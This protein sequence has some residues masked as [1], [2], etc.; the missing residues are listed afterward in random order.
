MSHE[1]MTLSQKETLNY[2]LPTTATPDRYE[3]K[4]TP[5]LQNFTFSGEETIDITVHESASEIILNAAELAIHSAHITNNKGANILATVSCDTANERAS[6]VLGKPIEPGLWALHIKFSGIL[7][8]RLHG[9]YRS[10]YQDPSGTQQVIATTQFE[11]TDARRAFPCW[12]EPDCKAVFKISLVIDPK[13]TAISNASVV[14]EETLPGTNKKQVNFA[15]TMKM[16]TYLVAFIVGQFEATDPIIV[17]GTPIRVWCVPGKKHLAK[18]ALDS[19]SASLSFFSNYYEIPY[20]GDKMDLIAL[21]DFASG[22]MENL[23]AITFRENALLVDESKASHAELERI[24]DVVAHEIAHMWFGDLVTMKWW[25]GIWLNEAFATFM[26]MLAVDAWKPEWRRWE[27][28]G[29]SRAAAFA[30]DGLQSTRSIEFPVH[31]PDEAAGMFD[32][33]TYEKGASVLRMLEQYLGSDQL[34]QGISLYLKKHQYANA[35]TTDLWDA[36]EASSKQPVRQLM[37]SWIFQGGYPLVSVELSPSGQ[38]ITLSQQRF[39]YL[40]EGKSSEQIFHIPIMLRAKTTK[41]IVTKK[42]LLT[43]RETTVDFDSK[44]DWIVVNDGGHG[45]YRVR[46]STELLGQ[47]TARLWENLTAIERFNL[48]SDTWAAAMAGLLPLSE[49][50]KLVQQFAN[51]TDKNVWAIVI[52]SLNYLNKIIEPAQRPFFEQFVAKLLQSQ[53]NRLGW[54]PGVGE[55]ELSKQLRGMLIGA[56]G[57]LGNDADMQRQALEFYKKYK[58]DKQTVDPNVVPALVSILAHTGDEVTYAGFFD[59]FKTAQ[60]P[61][62]EQRYL[63]SLA[64]FRQENLLKRTLDSTINGQVRTQNAPYLVQSVLNN[65]FGRELAWNFFQKNWDTMISLF[66]ENTIPRMCEGV[67]SLVKADLER[68]VVEFFATHKVKQGG[69]T[70]EQHLEKLHVAVAFKTREESN[71]KHCFR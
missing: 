35:E 65:V 45:F 17:S 51:E 8:D 43:K 68:Q 2:R 27:T 18:F 26:E 58:F 25:N 5:D 56:L 42:L 20:P 10:T 59:E 34:R 4:L 9:F 49:Y 33:L 31:H 15:E 13:L 38:A 60:T 47:L 61:Q 3:I 30:V 70:I 67:T 71:F 50:T 66:P 32:I 7:N 19:A 62:D 40:S 14:S 55:D 21:P 22:A 12:D 1:T 44:L 48:L 64:A 63:F 23:G 52:G 41:G 36:I 28:F 37:D 39:F 6:F 24:A 46:Y 53:V 54:A 16:S 57:T 29:V 11:A 69:K